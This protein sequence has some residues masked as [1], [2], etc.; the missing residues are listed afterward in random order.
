MPF[1]WLLYVVVGAA[2]PASDG[3]ALTWDG[4]EDCDAGDEARDAIDRL[5]GEPNDDA[6]HRSRV[7]AHAQVVTVADDA[8]A[9]WHLE[10][11]LRAGDVTGRR[12]LDAV[13]CEDLVQAT[14]LIVAIAIDPKVALEA[15]TSAA[16]DPGPPEP[17]P[18]APEP[19]PPTPAPVE[20]AVEPTPAD[21]SV[22]GHLRVGLGPAWGLV[23]GWTAAVGL[24]GGVQRGFW[25]VSLAANAHLPR[26]IDSSANPAVGGRFWAWTVGAAGCG[27]PPAVGG[28]ASVRFLLC[29]GLD[30]GLVHGVGV[31]DLQQRRDAAPWIG[32][33]AGPSVVWTPSRRL[34]VYLQADL[35][36]GIERPAFRTDPSGFLYRPAQVGFLAGL[37]AE[38]D[39]APRP[40]GST[41]R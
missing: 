1:W 36:V 8:A 22:H 31:G 24:A 2:T 15:S 13:S 26:E 16:D 18:A 10:L 33:R 27:V 23:P 5:L 20:P 12:R 19:D 25:R 9:K 35:V 17:T 39:F 30:A 29:A 38:F 34:G 28:R 41:S 11:E 4:P 3:Y 40:P 6:P 7:E 14:A 32:G 21:A 37:G